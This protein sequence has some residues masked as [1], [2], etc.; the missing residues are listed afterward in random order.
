VWAT[1]S[2][3]DIS[4]LALEGVTWAVNAGLLNGKG[5]GI[6]IPIGNATRVEVAQILMDFCENI[7]E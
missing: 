7:V 1:T 4:A 6:L 3:A 2:Y 5:N